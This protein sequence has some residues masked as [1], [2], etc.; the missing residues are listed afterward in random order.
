M[1]ARF[2]QEA[3]TMLDFEESKDK[4]YMGA[5][6][7]SLV[8]SEKEKRNTA[9][10]EAGHAICNIYCTQADPLHKVTIIPR[11][12]ALGV[13]WSL[14][15]DDK[16]SQ[17]KEYI[18]DKV[19]IMMGGRVAEELIFHTRTTGAFSD[20]KEATRL[21]RRMVCDFGMT[22]E[23]GP[24]TYGEKNEQIFLGRDF[25][26]HR[27]Y[28]EKTAQEIDVLMRS[29]V[30]VQYERAKTILTEHKDQLEL[31]ALALIEFELLDATEVKRVIA[32]EVLSA[33]KRTRTPPALRKLAK[34]KTEVTAEGGAEAAKPE[35]SGQGNPPSSTIETKA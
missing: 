34:E 26:Q 21:I 29:A 9:Y 22:D 31:L 2:G 15:T 1:A 13:T 14:P 20:I 10:H 11:G 35:S 18:L 19:C 12:R 6:R 5:E 25:N 7:R 24:L 17:S 23:L 30:E 3:V 16:Y 8:L 4:V 28:S 33:A 27:D 32:G